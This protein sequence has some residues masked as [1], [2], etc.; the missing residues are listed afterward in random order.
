MNPGSDDEV[1]VGSG[2]RSGRVL[3]QL[4]E[5][6][7]RPMEVEV[8]PAAEVEDGEVDGVPALAEIEIRPVPRGAVV[9]DPVAVVRWETGGGEVGDAGERSGGWTCAAWRGVSLLYIKSD[10]FRE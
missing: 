1:L 8:V 7:D 3:A 10:V 5:E 9:A 4:L 2:L 6:V